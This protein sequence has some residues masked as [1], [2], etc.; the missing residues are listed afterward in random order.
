MHFAHRG[1]RVERVLD[2]LARDH[3]I[4]TV[5]GQRQV[6]RVSRH[7]RRLALRADLVQQPLADVERHHAR[8]TRHRALAEPAGAAADVEHPF[9]AK[10]LIAKQLVE[11]DLEPALQIVRIRDLVERLGDRVVEVQPRIP[12]ALDLPR[13]RLL[14]GLI[15]RHRF[16]S[17]AASFHRFH[18]TSGRRRATAQ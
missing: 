16:R 4:E 15:R 6:A 2:A 1:A 18:V 12:R 8:A 7:Q 5:R 13:R 3:E 9:A 11:H 17:A 14:A 10:I